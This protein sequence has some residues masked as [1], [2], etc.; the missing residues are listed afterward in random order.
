[1]GPAP[2]ADKMSPQPYVEINNQCLKSSV[3]SR[4]SHLP[5]RIKIVDFEPQV[6]GPDSR[7][8]G[9]ALSQRSEARATVAPT[10]SLDGLSRLY[11]RRDILR[12]D[13]TLL[14]S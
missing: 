12:L 7:L 1:M 14:R 2:A 13:I 4:E 10:L 11:L 5:D 9:S 6:R 8:R 3:A